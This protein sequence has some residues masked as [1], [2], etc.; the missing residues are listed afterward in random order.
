MTDVQ[1]FVMK[2][3]AYVNNR[4]LVIQREYKEET[5]DNVLGSLVK[6]RGKLKYY[7]GV[8]LEL[9]RGYALYPNNRERVVLL[10]YEIKKKLEVL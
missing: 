2:Q 1:T 7:L 8:V 10:K 3:L 4:L 9:E 5:D 6:Y